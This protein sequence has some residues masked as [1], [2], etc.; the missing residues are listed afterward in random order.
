MK[1]AP[2]L[3]KLRAEV[4]AANAEAAALCRDLSE[5]QLTWRPRQKSWSIAE[6][7]RHLEL[8]TQA[9]LPNLDRALAEARRKNLRS[10]G[11]FQLGWK[12]TLFVWYSEPP[13]FIRLPAPKSIVPRL[14]GAASE[15]LPAFLRSQRLI[16]E[17]MEAAAG[18]DLG[19]ARFVSPFSRLI[20]M[21]LLAFFSV[22]TA[23]TRRH[24]W[25]IANLRRELEAHHPAGA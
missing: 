22:Q 16:V 8:V 9:C 20:R 4:T 17:R 15:T 13:P 12:G 14:E 23:H 2:E 19:R 21:N 5:V 10:P 1:L 6:H 24:L 25:H 18:L 11:P 3:E 7:F